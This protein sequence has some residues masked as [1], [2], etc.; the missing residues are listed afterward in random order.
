MFIA[1]LDDREGVFRLLRFLVVGGGT[2]LI[3]VGILKVLRTRFEETLAFTGSWIA[4]TVVHY[5]A[6]RFWAL[7]SG[8]DDS[9]MQFWEYLF[10]VVLSYGIN[11]GT[12]KALRIKFGFSPGWATLLAVPPSTILVYL[13]F[14]YRVFS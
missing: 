12:F 5:V 14:N 3:Q 8:R 13:I 7:P 2:A 10:V 9:L 1:F 6:N 11:L 4:S